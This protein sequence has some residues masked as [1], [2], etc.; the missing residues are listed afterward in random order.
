MMAIDCE[1]TGIDVRHGCRPF[2]VTVY[3]DENE[4]RGWEWDVDPLT[5]MPQISHKDLREVRELLYDCKGIVLQNAA[6]DAAA[7]RSINVSCWPWDRTEDTLV[8]SH[9]LASNENHDLG[10][11]A[12]KYCGIEISLHESRLKDAVLEARRRVETQDKYKDWMIARSPK[13][14][15]AG[16]AGLPSVKG[17]QPWR[18][19]F[20]LPRAIAQAEGYKEDHPWWTVLSN[21]S[22][23]DSYATYRTWRRIEEKLKS[24][25]LWEIYRKR[26]EYAQTIYEMVSTGITGNRK[27]MTK[28]Y[29][30]CESI[31]MVQA[32]ICTKLAKTRDDFDLSLPKNGNNNSLRKYVFDVLKLPVI[33]RTETEKPSLDAE[34][35]TRW[36]SMYDEGSIERSFLDALTEM[37]HHDM[38]KTMIDVYDRFSTNGSE[39]GEDWFTIF[40]GNNPTGTGTLRG[41]STNPP[42]QNLSKR[43]E[44]NLREIFG[45]LPGWV[46]YSMDGDNLELRI[47]AYEAG[48]EK[49]IALFERPNEPPYFGSNHLLVAHIVF[50]DLFEKC[51]GRGNELDGRIFKDRHPRIY[52]NVKSGN[53]AIACGAAEHSGTVDRTFGVVGAH[54]TIKG[55]FTEMARLSE[56]LLAHAWRHGYVETIPDKS[57]NPHRGYPIL[58]GRTKTGGVMPTTPFSYHV[59]GTACWWKM[60]GMIRC[61]EQIRAWNKLRFPA[62]MILEVHDEVVFS[63]PRRDDAKAMILKRILEDG[64]NDIGVPITVSVKRHD[65]TYADGVEL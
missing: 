34:T 44:V 58:V 52:R 24:R 63:F 59:Q 12:Y 53:F 48:E 6:F 32:R 33:N 62:K 60:M 11:I 64:G 42:G 3:D 61:Q 7:M 39:H 16:T 30:R 51:R 22:N 36:M 35:I 47:P 55:N 49:M 54:R 50:K 15:R 10:F 40:P 45:P 25:G 18:F 1:T 5:R 41:T 28:I 43:A 4:W 56:W 29:N 19:D 20:W 9:I 14:N 23:A 46:W 2:F 37:R 38:G 31:A 26:M 8:A 13:W 65:E 27:R 21:Y 57:V 17:K